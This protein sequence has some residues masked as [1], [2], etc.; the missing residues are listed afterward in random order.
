MPKFPAWLLLPL[1]LS[2]VLCAEQS[3]PIADA[4]T[5]TCDYPGNGG[6]GKWVTSSSGASAA[7]EL[8]V[9]LTGTGDRRHCVTTWNL[10]VRNKAGI[11]R[12][13]GVAQRDDQPDDDEWIEENSF[14]IDAWSKDGQMVLASQI[15]AQGDWDETT[16]IIFDFNSS[17]FWRVELF[18]LFRAMIPPN[19][20]VIYRSLRFTPNGSVLIS[21]TSTDDDREPGSKACFPESNWTLDFRRSIITRAVVSKE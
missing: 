4:G 15:E 2:P 13:I 8:N 17:R 1:C 10:H 20:S 7:V 6:M 21:A 12:T 14:E 18:P 19:C 5:V 16:P 3:K 11:Q 9:K